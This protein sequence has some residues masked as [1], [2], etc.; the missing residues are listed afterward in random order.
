MRAER[1]NQVRSPRKLREHVVDVVPEPFCRFVDDP[2]VGRSDKREEVFRRREE[3]NAA[4]IDHERLRAHSG[5][6]GLS[7][8]D[9]AQ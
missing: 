8:R 9:D 4:R 6:R 1:L 2:S 3:R 7:D 5:S